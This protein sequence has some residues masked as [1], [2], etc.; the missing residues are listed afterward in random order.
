[1]R[2]SLFVLA[3]FCLL[4]PGKAVAVPRA[5]RTPGPGRASQTT[6]RIRDLSYIQGTSRGQHD[7]R[8]MGVV[9][10]NV[11]RIAAQGVQV[12]ARLPGG[13]H[14]V[15]RGPKKLSA[16]S[17][18]LYVSSSKTLTIG[19]GRIDVKATCSECRD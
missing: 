11:G 9:V 1:M 18:G 10:V 17:K 8:N 2:W 12:A 5:A 7:V 13:G 16:G 19:A 4:M 15:L 6:L 3:F 14:V